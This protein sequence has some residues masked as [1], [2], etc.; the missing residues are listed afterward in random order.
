MRCRRGSAW[1][2][3]ECKSCFG[4]NRFRVRCRGVWIAPNRRAAGRIGD[5]HSLA[6]ELRQEFDVR[7]LAAA[8]ARTVEL[9]QRLL[10][11]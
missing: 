2:K 1:L 11:L 7:R 4:I 5:D 9:E 6:E 10:E 8:G 3:K